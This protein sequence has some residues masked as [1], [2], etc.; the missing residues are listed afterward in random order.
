MKKVL[1]MLLLVFFLVVIY[2]Y[3]LVITNIPEEIIL[4][5]GE[6]FNMINFLGINFKSTK[7]TIETS[8]SSN[9]K[10][11][12]KL[13]KTSIEVSLFD[14]IFLKE[15]E[16]DVIPKTT[17]IPAGDIAGVKLYTSGVLVVR[18]VRNRSGR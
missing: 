4:F 15:I 14:K 1:K 9:E 5:Q 6:N 7:D 10:I 2:S 3:T 18:N 13:G 16:V 17:V 8:S 12:E 11:S